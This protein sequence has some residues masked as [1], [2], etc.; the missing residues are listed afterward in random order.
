MLDAQ[1]LRTA[2][3]K[4]TYEILSVSVPRALVDER[5]QLLKRASVNVKILDVEPLAILN[6][7]L[8][9]TDLEPGELLV[10]VNIGRQSSVLCLFSEKGPVVARYLEVG[11]EIFT[12]QIRVAFQ[13]SPFS[14]ESFTRTI[15]AAE[16]PKAEAACREV[17]ER[18][19]EDIRLS[20]TFY[21]TEYDRESLPRYA[22]AGWTDI[23]Y[24]GRWLGDRLGLSAPFEIM[25]PFQAV[26]VRAPQIGDVPAPARTAVPPG[27]RARPPGTMSARF[28][29]DLLHPGHVADSWQDWF[30]GPQGAR[31]LLVVAGICAGVILLVV[32]T[33]VLPPTFR[34]SRDQGAIPKLR[35]DLA[36][37]DGNL[38]LLRQ[39]L[40]ALGVEAK[41]QV[42]WA[43]VLNAFRRQTPPT[44]KLQKV[45]VGP[46]ARAG[47][48]SS[49]PGAGTNVP[50]RA[51]ESSRSRRSRRSGRGPLRCWR[52]RR[53]WAAC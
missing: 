53:S 15:S 14:T 16:A 23:P 20:L 29:L 51:G 18:M 31:R 17:V 21:R 24:I 9:L 1:I 26:D 10:V 2:P 32:I 39:D 40:Q 5:S 48:A 28:A 12:E 42:R 38:S 35:A 25:D 33:L 7:A 4:S 13:L 22:L 30:V 6:G 45:E 44:I 50:R 41:R 27:L 36:T 49:G 43:D 11:A 46:A 47:G 37:R 3:D 19:A 34:L 52:S 8:H